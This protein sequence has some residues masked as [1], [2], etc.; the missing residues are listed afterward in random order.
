M[1]CII[2]I[3]TEYQFNFTLYETDFNGYL[4]QYDNIGYMEAKNI[5][6][7]TDVVIINN[8]SPINFTQKYQIYPKLIYELNCIHNIDI[9]QSAIKYIMDYKPIINKKRSL[10]N[11]NNESQKR[12]KYISDHTSIYPTLYT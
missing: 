8:M 6:E 12:Q 3:I 10:E 11:N 1:L 5:I 4:K 7:N 9:Y 2:I